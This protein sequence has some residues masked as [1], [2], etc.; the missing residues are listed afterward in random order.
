MSATILGEKGYNPF[1]PKT[2]QSPSPKPT[3]PAAPTT[4]QKSV[5]T[6]NSLIQGLSHLYQNA[7][8]G[9]VR[10]LASAAVGY[11][12]TSSTAVAAVAAVTVLLSSNSRKNFPIA[13]RSQDLRS[14]IKIQVGASKHSK[15][16][17]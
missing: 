14:E 16:T 7:P 1:L 11:A 9:T 3:A 17:R 12:L 15:K 8:V 5:D 4:A 10:T 6:G 13:T 2:A